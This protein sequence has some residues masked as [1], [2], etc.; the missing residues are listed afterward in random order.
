[1]EVTGGEDVYPV[2]RVWDWLRA[3]KPLGQDDLRSV[4]E[5]Q[6]ASWPAW[7]DLPV[8]EKIDIAKGRKRD[9]D[10]FKRRRAELGRD[11][12]GGD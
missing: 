11:S 1:M 6:A 9:A 2:E 3:E 10:H 8:G 4:I 7:A 12:D 5:F